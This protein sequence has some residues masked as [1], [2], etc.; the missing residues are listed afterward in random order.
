[1]ICL[2]EA[3][4]TLAVFMQRFWALGGVLTGLAVLG[5]VLDAPQVDADATGAEPVSAFQLNLGY[6]G[7]GADIPIPAGL[8]TH[9]IKGDGRR[10]TS[11][12][13]VYRVVPSLAGLL[14]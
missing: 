14:K 10:I 11:E 2:E 1:M 3:M 8:L 7:V 5:L 12:S 4:N 6:G 9:S 13:A